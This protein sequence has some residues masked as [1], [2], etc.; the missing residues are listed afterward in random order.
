MYQ[1]RPKK[2]ASAPVDNTGFPRTSVHDLDA[3]R[4]P[5]P[6]WLAGLIFL[7]IFALLQSGWGA[8]R[9]TWV[10]R[11]VIH[12]ATVKPAVA[13]IR[14]ISPK[15]TVTAIGASIKAPG[16]GL[17][18]LNG[19]EGT[20]VMFLLAAA[21]ATVRQQWWHKPSAHPNKF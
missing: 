19:C 11:L 18:I 2:V 9:N 7:G 3:L 17:N 4:K 6:L 10:E 13:L 14:L 8:A 16:G 5:R 12:E 1:L 21:F 15:I 20:E